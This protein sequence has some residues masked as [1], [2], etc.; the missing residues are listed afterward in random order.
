VERPCQQQREGQEERRLTKNHTVAQ[1]KTGN[2]IISTLV[3]G[4][5]GIVL[6]QCAKIDRAAHGIAADWN[7]VSREAEQKHVS[8]KPEI[9]VSPEI[10]WEDLNAKFSIGSSLTELQKGELWKQYQGKKVRWQGPVREVS[11]AGLMEIIGDDSPFPSGR[12]VY[13][14]IIQS[15]IPKAAKLSRGDRAIFVGVLDSY[16]DF[17]FHLANGIIE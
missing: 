8:S 9:P 17:S 12:Q 2:V 13:V 7:Q 14:Q 6:Y 10:K 3:L 11:D 15:E 1:S 4:T 16:D 5:C